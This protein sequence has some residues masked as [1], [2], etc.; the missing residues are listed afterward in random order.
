MQSKNEHIQRKD[1]TDGMKNENMTHGM[2]L[3][4]RLFLVQ[5]QL[6]HNLLYLL[7]VY[8]VTALVPSLTACLLS[9][10]GK[11]SLTAVWISRLVIVCFLL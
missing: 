6:L 9:S 8:F 10:P 2:I 1:K 7:L 11:W 3:A 4:T 5:W